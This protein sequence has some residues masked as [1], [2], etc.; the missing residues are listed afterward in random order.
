M[1]QVFSSKALCGALVAAGIGMAP[2]GAQAAA[3]Y[4]SF[5]ELYNINLFGQYMKDGG[6]G[7]WDGDGVN[8]DS[9]VWARPA[10]NSNAPRAA[11]FTSDT[12]T[13]KPTATGDHD[14][15]TLTTHAPGPT[16][17]PIDPLQAS[18]GA[19]SGQNFWGQEGQVGQYARADALIET[20][21][22]PNLNPF[23]VLESGGERSVMVAEGYTT[24]LTEVASSAV[25]KFT[26]Y[27]DMTDLRFDENPLTPLDGVYD[28][29]NLGWT[30]FMMIDFKYNYEF[31]LATDP[32]DIQ[33]IAARNVGLDIYEDNTSGTGTPP[34]TS[35]VAQMTGASN[36]DTDGNGTYGQFCGN[37]LSRSLSRSNGGDFYETSNANA[38]F[39]QIFD[40][41]GSMGT[42]LYYELT[43]QQ[44][45]SGAAK[46]KSVPEP[47]ILALLGLGL[48]GFGFARRAKRV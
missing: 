24:N 41:T 40:L 19:T 34:S 2:A 27:L 17:F 11:V 30:G 1:K 10:S 12:S 13:T 16:D 31:E 47:S 22:L 43:F 46:A 38:G 5:F 7:V 32:G 3:Y 25:N 48:L 36:C 26:G 20:A 28:G 23:G 14:E 29:T 9:L 39:Q 42:T 44:Q 6:N 33:A 18:S 37:A 45:V 35:L 15:S 4:Y 8:G 21:A